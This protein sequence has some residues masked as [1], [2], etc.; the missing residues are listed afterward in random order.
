VVNG[1]L[2]ELRSRQVSWDGMVGGSRGLM[3]EGE[4]C[5]AKPAVPHLCLLWLGHR[6]SV[7]STS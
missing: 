2:E 7:Y 1:I 5:P 4:L 6:A 3:D